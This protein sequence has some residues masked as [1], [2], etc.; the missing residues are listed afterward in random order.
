M[1]FQEYK[2]LCEYVD[3]LTVNLDDAM[4]ELFPV[5]RSLVSKGNQ[6][7]TEIL[8]EKFKLKYDE[9]ILYPSGFEIGTWSVPNS[10]DL[11][12]F[13][14]KDQSGNVLFNLTDTNLRVTS[15]SCSFV[16]KIKLED[17]L[18]RIHTK[19][20]LPNAVPYTTSYYGKKDW[21]ICL[22]ENEKMKIIKN[23][24]K[25]FDVLIKVSEKPSS[26]VIE[27][28]NIQGLSDRFSLFWTYNCHPQLAQNELSGVAVWAILLS[29]LQ[30]F[31]K[32]KKFNRGY[33]FAIGP[34]TIGAIALIDFFYKQN[35]E[36]EN[37]VVLT[38]LGAESDLLSVQSARK[39]H[40][41]LQ[42]AIEKSL[43]DNDIKNFK[44]D[45]FDMRGS[46]ERQFDFPSVNIETSYFSTKKY[47]QYPQYHT[48]DDN[49]E[50][51]SSEQL[52]K[53][54]KIYLYV[55]FILE[56]NAFY[57]AKSRGEPMLSKIGLW[58]IKNSGGKVPL[59]FKATDI[60]VNCDGENDLLS[61]SLKVKQPFF[62]VLEYI[63]VFEKNGL[64][65]KL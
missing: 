29:A 22:S 51:I 25:Y 44:V 40:S 43:L 42:K 21:S 7:T 19:P 9:R 26:L 55:I 36:P 57:V 8:K 1:N 27:N 61:I 59:G 31:E 50:F 11:I 41:Y 16:G 13:Q 23:G 39:E 33:L 38:C 24:S 52:R 62:K 64:V 54:S 3:G 63:T 46:D 45:G 18:K 47:H 14:L 56:N 37:A 20:E 15:G 65:E 12:E 49:L 34:E 58:T 35:L 53:S 32:K 5:R 48:S 28:Y 4:E 30:H 60:L 6:I 10:W 17:L 2:S